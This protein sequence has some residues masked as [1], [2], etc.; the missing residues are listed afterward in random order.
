MFLEGCARII[1]SK[2]HDTPQ[3]GDGVT[4]EAN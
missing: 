3:E 1:S 2:P 4:R